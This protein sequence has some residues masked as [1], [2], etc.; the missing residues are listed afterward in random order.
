M[1]PL[2]SIHE[3]VRGERNKYMPRPRPA[4]MD[5]ASVTSEQ[6]EVLESIALGIFTDMTNSGCSLQE[7]LAAIY[8]SGIKHALSPM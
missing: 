3:S 1:N 8:L 5:R 2:H 7:T 4:G 6:R